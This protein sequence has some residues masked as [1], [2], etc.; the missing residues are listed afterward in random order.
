MLS[1][2]RRGLA[3]R[4]RPH[5]A[6]SACRCR[7]GWHRFFRILHSTFS[8]QW[9]KLGRLAALTNEN[10]ARTEFQY[11]PVG[12]LLHETGFDGKAT[13][14]HYEPASGVLVQVIDANLLVTAFDFDASGRLTRRR[15]GLRDKEGMVAEPQAE[16]FAYDG[17]G[18][19][20]LAENVEMVWPDAVWRQSCSHFLPGARMIEFDVESTALP[21]A[22]APARRWMLD[23]VGSFQ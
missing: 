2:N 10:G 5:A 8:Y 6:R 9:D 23:D 19:L 3:H 15:A 11:E 1:R 22:V 12:R 18:R 21:H 13:R 17:N 16:T 7:D 20:I 14:Y 4:R